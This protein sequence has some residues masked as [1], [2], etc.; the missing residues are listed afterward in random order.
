ME[1]KGNGALQDL[2]LQ[3]NKLTGA[4]GRLWQ[5]Q[6][7]QALCLEHG[8]RADAAHP[9]RSSARPVSLH[10]NVHSRGWSCTGTHRHVQNG[11]HYTL[12]MF[13]TGCL[14]SMYQQW[15]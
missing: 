10:A 1:W 11:T 4:C 14:Q 6:Y 13:N 9:R 8:V 5:A 2:G 3:F 12:R 7:V 15:K